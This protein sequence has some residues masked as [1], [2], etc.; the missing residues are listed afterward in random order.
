MKGL[1]IRADNIHRPNTGVSNTS[2]E[3]GF[4]LLA[5]PAE[6]SGIETSYPHWILPESQIYKQKRCWLYCAFFSLNVYFEVVVDWHTTIISAKRSSVHS[7]PYPQCK[8]LVL[9]KNQYIHIDTVKLQTFLS[10]QRFLMLPFY[11]HI[12]FLP[13][14][15]PSWDP[16]NR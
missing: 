3:A 8:T 1:H 11:G 5:A 15:V 9:Y 12:H 4:S 10:P 6:S 13:A 2:D 7:A 16:D 14:P